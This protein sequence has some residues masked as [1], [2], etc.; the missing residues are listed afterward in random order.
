MMP[1]SIVV[2]LSPCIVPGGMM[3]CIP[4]LQIIYLHQASCNDSYCQ[5]C[6]QSYDQA[7][8]LE[9]NIN[10]D[11]CGQMLWDDKAGEQDATQRNF[12]YTSKC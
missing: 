8:N 10:V 4:M 1:E 11:H 6:N 5:S 2:T 9:I 3:S 12:K 7:M